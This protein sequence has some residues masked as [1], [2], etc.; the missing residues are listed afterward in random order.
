[1]TPPVAQPVGRP[2]GTAGV[3]ERMT[4]WVLDK[5]AEYNRGLVQAVRR[6]KT[7]NF[8]AAAGA[9]AFLSFLYGVFHAV[10]PGHGKAIISSYVL[11]NEQT[12]RRGVVIGSPTGSTSAWLSPRSG[13]VVPR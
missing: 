10:G 13:W 3:F 1:M 4:A 5:Q 8:F 2:T 6:F 11:A 12:A 9:L 7:D